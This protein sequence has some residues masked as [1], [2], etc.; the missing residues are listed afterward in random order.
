MRPRSTVLAALVT[1]LGLSLAGCGQ[2]ARVPPGEQP[3]ANSRGPGLSAE[4]ARLQSDTTL[5][6][7]G[8]CGA[9][10]QLVSSLAQMPSVD[11]S[12]PRR[13]SRTS[14]DLLG[15]MI[16]GLERTVVRLEGLGP[17][18]VPGADDV[19]TKAVRT[20]TAIRDRALGAK[21]DLDAAADA[22]ASRAAMSSAEGPLDE[23]GRLN[24]LEG[25]DSIPELKTASL[26]AP[27]C[28]QLTEESPAPRFDPPA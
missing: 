22:E 27:T 21:Q 9:V 17:A 19:K 11:P 6:A 25:F 10:S 3:E 23:I 15:V 5:W 8:Y 7:D 13:A 28:R 4:E 14:S 26:R 16:D 2:Q 12:T 1:A 18:P 24:L 20:Y